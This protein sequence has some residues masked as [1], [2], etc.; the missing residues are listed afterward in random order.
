MTHISDFEKGILTTHTFKI[1]SQIIKSRKYKTIH[2][3]LGRDQLGFRKSISTR[4]AIIT[5][6]IL[7]EKQIKRNEDTFI[8]FVDLEK[9]FDNVQLNQLFNI[10]EK[11]GIKYNDR[12]CIDNL[13]KN[14]TVLIRLG[15][16]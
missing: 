5:L 13:Y 2:T 9:A 12:R 16:E 7:L 8:A 6:R 4:E 14:Q 3:N 15:R 11:I 1:I 10:L